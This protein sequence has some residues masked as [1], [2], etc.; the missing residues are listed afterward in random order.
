[1]IFSHMCQN[2]ENYQ[3]KEWDAKTDKTIKMIML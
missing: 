2:K 3:K 1:M